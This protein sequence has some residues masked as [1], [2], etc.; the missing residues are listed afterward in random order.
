MLPTCLNRSLYERYFTFK[1]TLIHQN[2]KRTGYIDLCRFTAC[3]SKQLLNV[4]Q[5]GAF[6]NKWRSAAAVA[7]ECRSV[8]TVARVFTP[9]LIL[10]RLNTLRRLVGEYAPPFCPSNNQEKF[11]KSSGDLIN[12]LVHS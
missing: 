9:V 4:P 7:K 6:S 3:M 5:V 8:C 10:A 1:F 2:V 12:N 11:I